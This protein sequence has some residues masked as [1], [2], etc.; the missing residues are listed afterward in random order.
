MQARVLERLPGKLLTEDNLRS[1]EV[2]SVTA[3]NGFEDFGIAPARVESDRAGL[4][5]RARPNQ[6]QGRNQRFRSAA[7]RR[8]N[9]GVPARGP[10]A[11]PQP[12]GAST[13]NSDR[14]E[15]DPVHRER[16]EPDPGD[17]G[18]K[19]ADARVGAHPRHQRPDPNQVQSTAA[20]C[21]EQLEPPSPRPRAR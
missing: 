10:C 15:R 8:L 18:E 2:D 13:M 1:L 19:R 16:P 3:R 21:G 17:E 6:I 20:R 9:P 12:H 11:E 14:A 4:S 7:R 5:R